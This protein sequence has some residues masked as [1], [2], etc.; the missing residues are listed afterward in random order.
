M[1]KDNAG[2][3]IVSY[4]EWVQDISALHWNIE[5][6]MKELDRII[7]NSFETIVQTKHEKGVTY[8][9]AAL[10]VAVKRVSTAIQYRGI[11]P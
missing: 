4:F 8:R 10:M 7:L 1:N 11:F 5:R 3:L 9:Q 2:G 6:V